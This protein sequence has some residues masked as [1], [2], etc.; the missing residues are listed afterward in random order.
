M[1]TIKFIDDNIDD[2]PAK[3]KLKIKHSIAG[4]G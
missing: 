3:C 2:A 1:V 4:P